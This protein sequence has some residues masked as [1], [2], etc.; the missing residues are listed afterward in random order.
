MR[1]LIAPDSFKETLAAGEAAEA[2]ARGIRAARPDAAL[3]LCPIADGGEGTVEAMAAATGGVRI[4]TRV[5]GPLGGPTDALWCR[6]PDQ[7]AVIEMAAAAGIALTPI[8]RRD[9]TRTTTYGVGELLRAAIDAGCRSIVMGV[10]GSA[11]CDGGIGAA[12]ALGARL[13][14][15]DAMPLPAPAG[16]GDLER[17]AELDPSRLPRELQR[18]DLRIACDVTNPLFGVNGSAAVYAPQKGATPE[19]VRQ[20]DEGLRRLA[21]RVGGDPEQPGAGAAGGLGF[22]CAALLGAR[23]ERGIDLVLD[24]V[25]FDR[26]LREADLVV[27]GEGKLDTQSEAGKACLGVARRARALGV[28]TLALVGQVGEGTDP[29]AMPEF[30]ARHAIVGTVAA[31]E[32]AMRDPSGSL[33]AL[34]SRVF[35]GEIPT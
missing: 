1:V 19:Q 28:P 2:I 23:L 9:P 30:L 29:A 20:L 24:A 18:L 6:L 34:A 8:R 21:Q 15:R 10:G 31:L 27:T 26:R 11:T 5:T 25:D 14:G 35:D 13:L 33:E 12:Q 7:T 32:Q 4:T 3:D 16:G 17:L 22:M